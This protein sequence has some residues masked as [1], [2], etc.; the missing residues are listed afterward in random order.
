M[1]HL[2]FFLPLSHFT[3]YPP[4]F[5]L[6]VGAEW[7]RFWRC[8]LVFGTHPVNFPDCHAL[9]LEMI[10]M[11]NAIVMHKYS[12]IPSCGKKWLTQ[13][14][15]MHLMRN[16]KNGASVWLM[17]PLSKG[18]GVFR[19]MSSLLHHDLTSKALT[20]SLLNVLHNAYQEFWKLSWIQK[21]PVIARA[22]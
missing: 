22:V 3:I 17:T 19:L 10:Y 14:E 12:C 4:F 5:T 21:F 2:F 16:G 9:D 13:S 7:N 18:S 8:L 11:V 15:R 20:H 6:E 1:D